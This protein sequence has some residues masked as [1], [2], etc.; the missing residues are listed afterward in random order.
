MIIC[1]QG[2]VIIGGDFNAILNMN[3]REQGNLVTEAEVED[4]RS[5]MVDT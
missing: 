4:F 2:P 3:D 1:L 5:W